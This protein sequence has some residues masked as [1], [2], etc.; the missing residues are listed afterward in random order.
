[1]G[2][3][4]NSK[5]AIRESFSEPDSP[6]WSK[7]CDEDI[8]NLYKSNPEEL[9]FYLRQIEKE[10]NKSEVDFTKLANLRKMIFQNPEE[11]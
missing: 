6:L 9:Q 10:L 8:Q 1:M 7:E 3:Y 4:L 11:S 2:N 5:N